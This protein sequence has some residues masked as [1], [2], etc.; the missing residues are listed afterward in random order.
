MT[1][2]RTEYAIAT[3]SLKRALKRQ[4]VTYKELARRLGLSE[5]G[6]KK[7]LSAEDGSFQRVARICAELGLTMSELLAGQDESMLELAY[8]AAQQA[9]L[10]SEPRAL[11]LYWALV[12][13]RRPLAEAQ[14]AAGLPA[15]ELFSVLRKLDRLGLLELLPGDRLRVPAVR[16]IRWVG[17]GPL[18]EKLYR[19]WSAGFLRAVATPEAREGE[20][21]L[22]RYFRASRKTA[23][24]LMAALRDLETEF[25]R[26]AIREMRTEAPGLVHLRWMSAVDGRSFLE[27]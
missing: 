7:I 25:V 3:G 27:A 4:G 22:I 5:S 13:E 1:R 2:H 9:Y 23:D 12:Y 24:E 14:K 6:V 10:V 19:E 26:R 17:G 18:V 20:L 8:S 11:R 21:F 16:Q 15:K